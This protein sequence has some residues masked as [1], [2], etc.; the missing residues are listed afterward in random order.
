[1]LGHVNQEGKE[2]VQ[3]FLGHWIQ[4]CSPFGR[5]RVALGKTRRACLA[6]NLGNIVICAIYDA[7]HNDCV[8]E[9]LEPPQRTLLVHSQ[10]M[11]L[12]GRS[13]PL[14]QIVDSSRA[15]KGKMVGGT[16][17]AKTPPN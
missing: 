10:L 17:R 5:P 2:D 13:V 3:L 15:N 14:A 8:E 7:C 9:Q 16:W 12:S 4:L 1:M 11:S 6:R